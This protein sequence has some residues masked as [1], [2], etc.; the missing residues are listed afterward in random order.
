VQQLGDVDQP[1]AVDGDVRRTLHVVP[2]VQIVAVR[3]EEL[4]AVVLAV[5]DQHAAVRRHRDAV[6]EVELPRPDARLTP[7]LNERPVRSEAV[8]T[9]IAVAVRD[10]QLAARCD[11]EVG[12]PVEG[13]PAV[14]DARQRAAIVAG[15][16]GDAGDADRLE[17]LALRREAEDRLLPLVHAPDRV[18][19][20]DG[21]AV[22][23]RREEA[24]TPRGDV[25]AVPVVDEDAR[26]LA[27][28][29]EDAVARIGVRADDIG[30]V[31]AVGQLLPPLDHLVA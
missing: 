14:G 4:D 28:D 29:E 20:R 6:D 24:L 22:G 5:G 17:H 21:Q 8:D 27:G 2:L 11:G 15:V 18:V 10:V 1:V 23:A 3:A 19:G 16:G 31:E 7:R 9:R 12:G 30:V 25:G 26:L 13:W